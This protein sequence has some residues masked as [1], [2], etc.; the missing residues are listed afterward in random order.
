MYNREYQHLYAQ[1]LKV[2]TLRNRP[3]RVL[4]KDSARGAFFPITHQPVALHS[5]LMSMGEDAMHFLLVQGSYKY[6]KDIMLTEIEVV[7]QYSLREWM[8]GAESDITPHLKA[9]LM[10][11][12]IDE[13]YHAFIAQDFIDQVSSHTG[14][15]PTQHPGKVE[16]QRAI[17]QAL[18]ALPARLHNTFCLMAVCIAENTLTREIVDYINEDEQLCLFFRSIISDHLRDEGRH[19]GIYETILS[20]LWIITGSSDQG[21][22]ARLLP[23]FLK[24]Y[25]GT[26][27][28]QQ[29][30]F[31]VLS[32]LGL[33]E[34]QCQR[35]VSD[36][37]D[38]YRLTPE[39]GMLKNILALF[40]RAGLLTSGVLSESLSQADLYSI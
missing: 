3:H 31:A 16:L 13:Y 10:T 2:A 32:Q 20:E 33:S 4:D 27:Y 14:I 9:I 29:H 11:I 37:W 28:Q 22:I 8:R 21:L 39:H 34:P 1:W 30:D 18:D 19:C 26:Y 24:T 5:E 15:E 25:L 7:S 38:D 36:T 23:G 12:V 35:I 6:M 17:A 40:D